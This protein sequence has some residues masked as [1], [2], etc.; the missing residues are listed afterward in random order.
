M[1]VN[2]VNNRLNTSYTDA[3]GA[4]YQN[5]RQ[6]AQKVDENPQGK[7]DKLVISN[8]ARTLQSKKV[9]PKDLDNIRQRVESGYYNRPEVMAKVADSL[10]KV[11]GEE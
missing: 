5:P 8:E 1:D 3:A 2:G 9:E 7:Q 6:D 4:N 11:L 10:L